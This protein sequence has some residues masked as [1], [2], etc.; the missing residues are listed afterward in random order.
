MG[1]S[2]EFCLPTNIWIKNGVKIQIQNKYRKNQKTLRIINLLFHTGRML[3]K[4]LLELSVRVRTIS[5][6]H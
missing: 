6:V 5:S 4:V 2:Q 1:Y 3:A